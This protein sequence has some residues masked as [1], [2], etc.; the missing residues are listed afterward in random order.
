MCSVERRLESCYIISAQFGKS[1]NRNCTIRLSA[2]IDSLA[3]RHQSANKHVSF[4]YLKFACYYFFCNISQPIFVCLYSRNGRQCLFFFSLS[5]AS[6]YIIRR[7]TWSEIEGP[8]CVANQSVRFNQS[9]GKMAHW[10]RRRRR[11]QAENRCEIRFANIRVFNRVEMCEEK[12]SA[13]ILNVY[14]WN[15]AIL[16]INF[17]MH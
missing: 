11:K 17:S 10:R 14:F 4:V 2:T 15:I 16:S 1:G 8:K 3:G 13:C 6:V 12:L 5:Q 7:I 9:G